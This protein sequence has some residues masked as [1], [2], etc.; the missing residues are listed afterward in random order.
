MP[1]QYDSNFEHKTFFSS[2]VKNV[3][4]EDHLDLYNKLVKIFDIRH[5][6]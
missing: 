4:T 2:N 3:L 6:M 1:R 5:K